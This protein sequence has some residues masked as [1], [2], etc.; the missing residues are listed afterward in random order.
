MS[1]C[2]RFIVLKNRLQCNSTKI[3]LKYHTATNDK[4]TCS[5]QSS[6]EPTFPICSCQ[7]DFVMIYRFPKQL[8]FTLYRKNGKISAHPYPTKCIQFLD[9]ENNDK[10]N[11]L[12][13]RKQICL[14]IVWGCAEILSSA[15][16]P[17][18]ISC[19]ALNANSRAN[20]CIIAL[21]ISEH[22]VLKNWFIHLAIYTKTSKF[23]SLI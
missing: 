14:S 16:A 7:C 6:F 1:Y 10:N 20:A 17:V 3:A 13:F 15:K 2:W 4:Q 8:F 19:R 5:F 22:A 23:Y 12:P 21:V 9:R 18:G 11:T